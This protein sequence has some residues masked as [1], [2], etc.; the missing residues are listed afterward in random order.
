[1]N[2]E[3]NTAPQTIR[4]DKTVGESERVILSVIKRQ[5]VYARAKP[6]LRRLKRL[7]LDPSWFAALC[8]ALDWK[9][10]V[11]AMRDTPTPVS[12]CLVLASSGDRNVGDQAMLEAVLSAIRDDVTV[13]IQPGSSYEYRHIQRSGSTRFTCIPGV[14]AAPGRKHRSG[15]LRL[16]ALARTH[17]TLVVIGADIID[18]GYNRRDAATLWAIAGAIAPFRNVRIVG[19]S[20]RSDVERQL[21]TLASRA[22]SNGAKAFVRDPISYRRAI[23]DGLTNVAS[24]ADTVF[25]L[26]EPVLD[27]GTSRRRAVVNVSGLIESRLNLSADYRALIVWLVARGYFVSIVPH[28]DSASKSDVEAGIR[29]LES[30]PDSVRD[31]V[32]LEPFT[33]LQ[34]E[35]KRRVSGADVVVTGR[36][37]LSILAASVGVPSVVLSTQGKVEGLM[38]LLGL[39]DW[40]V[41]PRVGMVQEILNLLERHLSA[42]ELAGSVVAGKRQSLRAMAMSNFE[43]IS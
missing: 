4:L 25:S 24:V 8:A 7:V 21:R 36:M 41:E 38:V 31:S 3:A 35:I 32:R 22:T 10:A 40:M 13:I 28:V 33:L 19:F 5:S 43:G 37:H 6:V 14:F 23:N 2:F 34:S 18:G 42:P 26:P 20:W 1:M 11:S 9:L 27:C 39:V 30:L 29:V 17:R 15:L 16:V 12:G